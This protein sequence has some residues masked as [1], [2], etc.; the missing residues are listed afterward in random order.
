MLG[1]D[2]EQDVGRHDAPEMWAMPDVITS[3][4][5]IVIPQVRPNRQRRFGLPMKMLAATFSDSAPL[6]S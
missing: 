3:S 2:P 6:H 1:L 5:R 4:A